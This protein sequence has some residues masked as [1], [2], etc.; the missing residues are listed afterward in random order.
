MIRLSVDTTSYYLTTVAVIHF[1]PTSEAILT[2]KSVF[3]FQPKDTEVYACVC[4]TRESCS[5]VMH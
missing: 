2:V 3:F 5:T 1:H 4:W